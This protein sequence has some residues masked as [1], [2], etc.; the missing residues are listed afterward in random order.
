MVRKKGYEYMVLDGMPVVKTP[1]K[2]WVFARSTKDWMPLPPKE[3]WNVTYPNF[4]GY[5]DVLFKDLPE[6]PEPP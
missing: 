4:N 6:P 5:W 1:K 2:M 3:E